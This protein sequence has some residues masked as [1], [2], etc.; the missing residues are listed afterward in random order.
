MKGEEEVWETHL[1]E[2]KEAGC[3]LRK[4]CLL[5]RLVN[6]YTSLLLSREGG[7]EWQAEKM[8]DVCQSRKGWKEVTRGG[9]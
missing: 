4:M 7:P 8:G 6:L 2:K 9:K 5:N 1:G 3:T